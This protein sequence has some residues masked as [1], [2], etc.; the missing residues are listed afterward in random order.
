[1]VT[2]TPLILTLTEFWGS[3]LKCLSDLPNTII[4]KKTKLLYFIFL[5]FV[6][7]LTRGSGAV[8]PVP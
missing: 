6:I 8:C 3:L 5:L 4:V 2:E 7:L 1:M